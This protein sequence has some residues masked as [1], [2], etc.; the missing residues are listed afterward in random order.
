[1]VEDGPLY[2]GKDNTIDNRPN[3]QPY[4]RNVTDM[5]VVI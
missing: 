4:D 5:L 3:N 2:I 1:V